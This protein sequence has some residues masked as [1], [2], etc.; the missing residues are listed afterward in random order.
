MKK[1]VLYTF[2]SLFTALNAQD[3]AQYEISPTIGYNNFDDSSKMQSK[4]MYGIRATA[5]TNE[6]YGYQLSYEIAD[7]VRY[8]TLSKNT[9]MHRFSGQII[10]NGEE[11]YKVLPYI[12]LGGGYELLSNE[13]T[14]DVSQGF[15]DGGIGFRYLMKKN[16]SINIEGKVLKKFD[17]NDMDY[18]MNFGVGYMFG[19]TLKSPKPYQPSVMQRS[20]KKSIKSN[21]DIVSVYDVKKKSN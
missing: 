3:V 8:S 2:L 6:Y 7:N 14:H 9:N 1:F 20:S 4:V 19:S 5:Y 10:I 15:I 21:E 11:E 17:T 12:I 16:I 18:T 13:T